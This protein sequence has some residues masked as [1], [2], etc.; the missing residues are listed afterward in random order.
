MDF[1]RNKRN[2][3][4][5]KEYKH[6]RNTKEYKKSVITHVVYYKIYVT[7]RLRIDERYLDVELFTN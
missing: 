2:K 1:I 4:N 3:R 6:K 7:L 5:T